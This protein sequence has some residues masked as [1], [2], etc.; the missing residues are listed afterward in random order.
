[1][2]WKVQVEQDFEFYVKES[3]IYSSGNFS[4][5]KVLGIGTPMFCV[6]KLLQPCLT[7]CNPINCSLPGSS[8]HQI[9]QARI[10]EWVAMP[11]SKASFQPRDRTH[12][13]YISCIGRQL[14]YQYHHMEFSAK[15]LLEPTFYF[16]LSFYYPSMC[17]PTVPWAHQA[18]SN[19]WVFELAIPSFRTSLFP[20]IHTASFL[21]CLIFHFSLQM[22]LGQ[23]HFPFWV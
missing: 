3:E 19:L 9:L 10:L 2:F 14:L 4:P 7:L 17:L 22:P 16:W 13:S 20:G 18:C 8:V 6:A 12:V 23:S 1:M 5:L 11:S 21:F 15:G